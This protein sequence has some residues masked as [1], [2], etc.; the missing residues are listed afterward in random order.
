MAA[1][2]PNDAWPMMTVP[3][4]MSER[5]AAPASGRAARPAPRILAAAAIYFAIVFAAGLLFGPV[6]VLWLEPWLGRT[7]AVLC[8]TPLLLGVMAFA[9][10]RIPAWT[11]GSPSLV[12]L[13]AIGALALCFQQIADLS[14]GFG[15]RGMTIGEQMA[16][17]AT[18][19]GWIYGFDLIVFALAP[20]I[21]ARRPRRST[22][23]AAEV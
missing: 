23:P 5:A 15:L 7:L 22:P 14:V 11:G 8:E 20:L 1:T 18:P 9:A 19:P 13:L 12:A 21:L 3:D 6:R 4:E 16:L 10:R 2:P 17:F